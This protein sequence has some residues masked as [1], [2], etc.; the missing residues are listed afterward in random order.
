MRDGG[1]ITVLSLLLN[2]KAVEFG[3]LMPLHHILKIRICL[4]FGTWDAGFGAEHL[5]DL[6]SSQ[7]D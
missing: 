4:V 1:I 7:W 2:S 3:L 5:Q 6:E